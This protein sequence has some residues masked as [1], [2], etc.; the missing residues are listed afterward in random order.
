[1]FALVLVVVVINF[2][3]INLAPGDPT[4]ILI[5]QTPVDKEY[6][7]QV[8]K[9]YGLDKPLLERLFT[10]ISKI[11]QGDFGISYRSQRPVIY[12]IAQALPNTVA[13]MGLGLALGTAFGILL[14]VI[15]STTR[16]KKV[17]S[18]VTIGSLLGFSIP[19]YWLG[20]VL[21]FIFAV[22]FGI[23]PAS[24][25]GGIGLAANDPRRILELLRYSI[26]PV[27]SVTIWNTALITQMT[28]TSMRENFGKEFVFAARARGIQERVIVFRHVLRNALIP[29]TS[30][31]SYQAGYLFVG[32]I[33][34]ET[35]FSWPGMGSLLIEA[36]FARD[37]PLLMGILLVVTV[38]IAVITLIT[39][40]I[41]GLL[42]PR[43]QYR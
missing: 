19:I 1:M 11:L 17:D 31:V 6:L 9:E 25:T 22:N 43:I 26:L 12:L 40:L 39:D 28:R 36:A 2:T 13:L 33:V 5:G 8:R 34:T 15:G 10:Y 18:L 24:G 42:D 4:Y 35:I 20:Q 7:D 32:A 37:Y 41:Y 30:L 14:G 3:I 23:L 38:G 21:I 29:I 27:A 16:H